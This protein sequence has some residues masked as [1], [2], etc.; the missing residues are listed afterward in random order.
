MF[1]LKRIYAVL[2][3][4]MRGLMQ[5]APLFHL[6]VSASIRVLAGNIVLPQQ[7]LLFYPLPFPVLCYGI[8]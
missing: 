2:N 7:Y 3:D 4:L 8:L 6:Q 1:S 5:L